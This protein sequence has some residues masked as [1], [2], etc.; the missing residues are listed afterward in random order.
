M[1]V[2]ELM[3]EVIKE[4][5]YIDALIHECESEEATSRSKT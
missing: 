1:S 5:G 2:S 4:T 3:E